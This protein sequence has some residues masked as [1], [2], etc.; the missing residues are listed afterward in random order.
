MGKH[1]ARWCDHAGDALARGGGLTCATAA[2]GSVAAAARMD[3]KIRSRDGGGDGG[4]SLPDG[5]LTR[6]GGA[7][8]AGRPEPSLE[9]LQRH[10][11]ARVARLAAG[12]G[13]G[14]SRAVAAR[15]PP[16]ADPQHSK[17]GGVAA[18]GR[19]G[20]ENVRPAEATAGSTTA[21]TERARGKQNRQQR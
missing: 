18:T 3:L 8:E 15:P 20:D 2:L 7:G 17:A 4:E 6:C 9:T 5:A 1:A 21:A 16:T 14:R 12:L 11:D 10:F 13:H 19:N